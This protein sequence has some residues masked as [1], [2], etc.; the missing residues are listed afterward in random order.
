[1]KINKSFSIITLDEK[2]DFFVLQ[3]VPVDDLFSIFRVITQMEK[4]CTSQ[5][6]ISL[7]AVQIGVPWN[8]FIVQRDSETCQ[9]EY[10]IN[11]EYSG[12]GE[13]RKSIEGCLSL[14][15][16]Q[17]SLRR[18][19]VDRYSSILVKGKQLKIS[20]SSLILE[21]VNKIEQGLFSV[22]FQ[23]EIDHYH[24]VL[25]SKIGVEVDFL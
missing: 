3:D 20:D 5:K 11:C 21:D 12:I 25:I 19:E 13:K 17:G 14:R 18:F 16:A 7:S 2:E 1:M 4:L 22:I 6:G 24:E 9:Y 8:L 15:D 10:Y 23:H